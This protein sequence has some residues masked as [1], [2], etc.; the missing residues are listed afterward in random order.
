V[1]CVALLSRQVGESAVDYCRT[2]GTQQ[3]VNCWKSFYHNG[4][5]TTQVG[6]R[7]VAVYLGTHCNIAQRER[8]PP[9]YSTIDTTVYR[10]LYT[11]AQA[12]YFLHSTISSVT[13]L[14]LSDV[15]II[16]RVTYFQFPIQYA[17]VPYGSPGTGSSSPYWF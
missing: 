16:C 6:T 4:R 17:F 15:S 11:D 10:Y 14:R 13:C 2:A 12:V 9:A 7:W 3:D 1:I 8:F 5:D